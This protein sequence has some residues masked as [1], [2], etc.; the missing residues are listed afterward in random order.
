MMSKKGSHYIRFW[1]TERLQKNASFLLR[2]RHKLRS[3]D[4]KRRLLRLN[5]IF[6]I[7]LKDHGD[8][9][10]GTGYIFT[11]QPRQ[12]FLALW[13]WRLNHEGGILRTGMRKGGVWCVLGITFIDGFMSIEIDIRARFWSDQIKNG[14]SIRVLT[15]NDFQLGSNLLNKK[16]CEYIV[17]RCWHSD[18]EPGSMWRPVESDAHNGFHQCHTSA[19]L[20]R[21]CSLT[22]VCPERSHKAICVFPASTIPSGPLPVWYWTLSTV[23]PLVLCGMRSESQGGC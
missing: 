4:G 7:E 8:I 9:S 10:V 14:S 19:T 20:R 15:S 22:G 17:C 13:I 23:P 6:N 12:L 11:S 21:T 5:A 2:V 16:L 18:G 1:N 3:L